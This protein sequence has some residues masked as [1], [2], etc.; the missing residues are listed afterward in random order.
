MICKTHQM[1]NEGGKVQ[2]GD[3][4]TG[5]RPLVLTGGP[6]VGKTS[7]GRALTSARLRA[8]FIDVDDV[9]QL[10]VAGGEPPWRGEQGRLQQELGVLNACCMAR[11]FL[12]FGFDVVIADV[13]TPRTAPVYRRELPHCLLVHLVV[14]VKEALRRA[15]TRPLWLT[16]EE[17]H[18]LHR[19][20][21]AAPPPVDRRLEVGEM[22]LQEQIN[23]VELLWVKI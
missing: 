10:V 11:R 13:V 18:G 12:R 16:D 22:S 17:F 15:A 4:A 14:P 9:R 7:T 6:A 1:L 21:A 8:A 5:L 20:D 19:N 23:A 3:R 2:A